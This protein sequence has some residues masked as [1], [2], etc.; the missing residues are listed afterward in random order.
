[1]ERRRKVRRGQF[2]QRKGPNLASKPCD[3]LT[4]HRDSASV[5]K[6]IGLLLEVLFWEFK[7]LRVGPV[8]RITWNSRLSRLS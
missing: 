5:A 6:W 4:G 3:G 2:G 8:T 7:K 1:M